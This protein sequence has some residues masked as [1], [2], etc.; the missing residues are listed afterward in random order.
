MEQNIGKLKVFL[1]VFGVIS[2]LLFGFL[3]VATLFDLPAMQE[4]GSM[5]FLRWDV[6]SKHVEL[7][8][9]SVYLTW[10]IFLLI[11]AKNP[12][13]NLSFLRFTAWANLVHGIVMTPQSMMLHGFMYKMF[14]DVAYCIVLAIGLFIL[15]PKG[16]QEKNL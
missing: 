2:I 6:L 1:K 9:E 11:A 3:F 4:G 13:A 14:T 10:G 5:R 8:I 7:M 16:I 12:M 15:L